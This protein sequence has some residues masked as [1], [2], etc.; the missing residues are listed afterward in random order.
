[1][2]DLASGLT[3]TSRLGCQVDITASFEGLVVSIP[4]DVLDL[5][6]DAPKPTPPA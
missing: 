2:L 1:M 3:D 5:R 6:P 4:R